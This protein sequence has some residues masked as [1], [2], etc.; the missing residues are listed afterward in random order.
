MPAAGRA[1]LAP[2]VFG[3]GKPRSATARQVE[4]TGRRR[5]DAAAVRGGGAFLFPGDPGAGAEDPEGGKRPRDP[6]SWG[7]ES[8]FLVV[9]VGGVVSERVGA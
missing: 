1:V 8:A 2:E 5:R 6:A 4:V 9:V 3:G 7:R